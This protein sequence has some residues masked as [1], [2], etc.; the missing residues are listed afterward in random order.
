MQNYINLNLNINPFKSFVKLTDHCRSIET[1]DLSLLNEELLELLK[2]ECGIQIVFS[3][4]FFKTPSTSL[5]AIHTDAAGGDLAKIN[6]IVG[7]KNSYME[8]Y[9]VN[10]STV[11]S[12]SITPSGTNYTR[13]EINEVNPIQ[14]EYVN[15]FC[16]VQVGIP[17][18]IFN[19]EEPRW[20]LCL[21]PMDLANGKRLTFNEAKEKL[22][23]F[24]N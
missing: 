16:L 17:H 23:K 3:E 14:R 6:F 24:L 21:I 13:Y 12:R 8:W 11:K 15:G 22:S 10:E 5:T 9:K 19:P 7:G 20:C 18:S 2:T 4:L 1:I